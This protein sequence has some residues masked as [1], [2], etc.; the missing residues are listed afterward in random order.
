MNFYEVCSNEVT[1]SQL[2]Q[3]PMAINTLCAIIGLLE[4]HTI[5]N[6]THTLTLGSYIDWVTFIMCV[7]IN[8]VNFVLMRFITGSDSYHYVH[9]VHEVHTL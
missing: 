2:T 6:S 1:L 5:T 4:I 8:D 9:S 7:V 3:Q